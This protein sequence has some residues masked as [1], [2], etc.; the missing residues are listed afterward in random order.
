MVMLNGSTSF[1]RFGRISNLGWMLGKGIGNRE[2][3]RFR[4]YEDV[5]SRGTARIHIE[6]THRN[7]HD[8]SG[9][10]AEGQRGAASAAEHVRKSVRIGRLVRAK[11]VLALRVVNSVERHDHVG[12]EGSAAT[13]VVIASTLRPSAAQEIPMKVLSTIAL[14]CVLGAPLQAQADGRPPQENA[15]QGSGTGK[16]QDKKTKKPRPARPRRTRR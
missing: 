2:P 10:P 8:S 12:R 5:R 4:I 11:Q 16:A 7:R 1:G 14:A 6:T 15:R 9:R 13:A 3:L